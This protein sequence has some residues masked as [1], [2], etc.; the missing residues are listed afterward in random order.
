[1]DALRAFIEDSVGSIKSARLELRLQTA[2][3]NGS[4]HTAA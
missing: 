4:E 3:P 2:A 1:V